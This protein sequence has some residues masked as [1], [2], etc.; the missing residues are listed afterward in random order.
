MLDDA[1]EHIGHAEELYL[2]L[3]TI[4]DFSLN[5]IEINRLKAL[6][7]MRRGMNDPSEQGEAIALINRTL[8]LAGDKNL[9]I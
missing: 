1:E 9:P 8:T 5:L 4:S 2:K 6:L 7:R 3:S